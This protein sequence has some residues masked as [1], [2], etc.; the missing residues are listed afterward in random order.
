MSEVGVAPAPKIAPGQQEYQKLLSG[1]FSADE[2]NQWRA[3]QTS[4]LTGGGFKPDEID[5]YWGDHQASTGTMDRLNGGNPAIHE[6][7]NPLEMLEAGWQMSVSGL[8]SRGGTPDTVAPE[9]AGLLGKVAEAMGQA[10]GDLPATVAGFFS[11]A[12]AGAAVPVGGETGLTELAG[13]GM[14]SAALPQAMREVIL[15]SYHRG[16]VHNWADFYAMATKSLWNTAKAGV[17]GLV[18]APVGGIVGSK[19]LSVTAKPFLATGANMTSQAVTATTVGGALDGH[20]PNADDFVTDAATMLGFHAAGKIVGAMGGRRFIPNEG[21]RRVQANLQDIY[22]RLGI[23][24]WQAIEKARS[25]PALRQEIL[26][27][28]VHGNPVTPN[29]NK[30]AP[31]EPELPPKKPLFG[32]LAK[33]VNENP[34]QPIEE[35]LPKIRGLEASGDQAVSPA[36]AIGRFQIMPGTARQYGFD[37]AKLGD[38]QYNEHVAR[39][40]L[41]DLYRRFRGDEDAILTA[42]N[43]GPGVAAKL[44]T[45]GPGTRLEATKGKHGWQ[46]EKVAADRS[47]ARLPMETQE[48]LA[49]GRAAG[50]EGGG[51]EPPAGGKPPGD[52]PPKQIEGGPDGKPDP[53]E[54]NTESRVANFLD[55]I[56]KP[57]EP[58]SPF[59]KSTMYRQFVSELGPARDIDKILE[60]EGLLDRSKDVGIEDMMRQTY[61]SAQRAGYFLRE[62][63]LDPITLTKKSDTSF[64]DIMHQIKAMGGNVDEFNTYRASLRTIEKAKQGIDTGVMSLEEAKANAADPK[65]QR[66]AAVNEA[67]QKWKDHGLEYGRDSG[68]FSQKQVDAMRAANTSHISLR[69]VMDQKAPAGGRRG[70]RAYNPLMRMEGS[71]RQ[72]IDP[73]M[74]DMDNMVQIVRMAD[75]N[76]AI[77]SV[78]GA[79]EKKGKLADLGLTKLSAPK[80]PELAEA[81]SNAFAPYGE[82]GKGFEPFLAQRSG[83]AGLADNQ[84]MFYR[85]GKAEVW[86][87]S[88]PMLATL[89]RGADST[90]EAN[91]IDSVFTAMANL[92]R[93]GIVSTPD[94]PLRNTM[95]DQI[96]AYVADPLSPPPFVTW[97][98]GAM[99]V[100]KMDDVYWDWV[101]KGGAGTALA[102]LDGKYIGREI[103]RLMDET[104]GTYD[105]MWNVVRHPIEAVTILAERLDAVTRVGYKMR[106]EDM[107]VD[108]FKAATMSRKAALDFAEKGTSSFLNMWS[109]WTPF[110]RPNILGLK[111]Y[112]EALA[113]KPAATLTKAFLA[114]T[115]PSLALYA[116]NYLQ[117][118][119]G[120]LPEDQQYQSLP[121]WQRDTMYVLPS[122]AGVRLRLPMPPI[123]G[124]A[125]GGLVNRFLDHWVEHDPHAFE[126]WAN[127]FFAQFLPPIIPTVA[128]PLS[129][130]IANHS[131]FSGKPLIPDSVKAASGDVQYTEATTEPAK[132]LSRLIGPHHADLADVS[133]I[134]LDNYAREWTGTMGVAVLRALGMPFKSG[135]PMQVADIPFVQSFIVRNPGMSAQPIQNFYEGMAKLEQAH[136][137]V[138]LALQ[139]N[140]MSV[141]QGD[142]SKARAYQRLTTLKSA[143]NIQ[144]SVLKNIYENETMTREEKLQTTDK[145]YSDLIAF[146]KLGDQMV[147]QILAADKAR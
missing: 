65:L 99:H 141:F 24:P 43:A 82:T 26:A 102:D 49:R 17:V 117:D 75:R 32:G 94:F 107:G 14:G 143:I 44:L 31:N 81:G 78:I 62:G 57:A 15:D 83:K 21:A 114:V 113:D 60:N 109:R 41:S 128:L 59:E 133:P 50:G 145:V 142:M 40:I 67:I 131:W 51:K 3:D 136:E 29:L 123:L 89:L 12:A 52:E 37:P 119:H 19:V 42:Y 5:A 85:D 56:G 4:K 64:I 72:I 126:N 23:P 54:L 120:G 46:Y 146:A 124:V 138:F 97:L 16:E 122:V 63:T 121:R 28:D 140:D 127:S 118:K 11:G 73:T 48:Y 79:I 110:L 108:S 103:T 139:Q 93:K 27:Q 84:F 20:V 22:R 1:G 101:A 106:A 8:I 25:D 13:A 36:G 105:Q 129:E 125:F 55:K 135:P 90:P 39:T 33:A 147:T 69:R 130:Q 104:T 61:G 98:R 76:R 53:F 96:V 18:S 137:N 38:P 74:A 144:R 6:A 86:E 134:V 91:A 35:L 9:H 88:D 45:A 116:L 87:A 112:G 80:A 132:A 58:D 95:R 100:W 77:G 7:T 30:S 47:E 70:F 111:Q 68:L 71:D 34:A 10:A 66:Y 92:A 115:M 2:A